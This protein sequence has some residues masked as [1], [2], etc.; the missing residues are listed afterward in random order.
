M[1][2]VI[3]R[4]SKRPGHRVSRLILKGSSANPVRQGFIDGPPFEVT[5]EEFARLD[6]NY[7]LEPADD[8]PGNND[9]T[10]PE[11]SGL[12]AAS[13]QDET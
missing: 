1:P 5:D 2:T 8:K 7:M 11:P 13:E 9:Q 4:G 3:L 12:V 10:L 6:V